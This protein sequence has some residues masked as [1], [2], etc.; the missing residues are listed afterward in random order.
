MAAIRS[1]VVEKELERSELK[2]S[3][4]EYLHKVVFMTPFTTSVTYSIGGYLR[5]RLR[6]TAQFVD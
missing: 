1:F 6:R 3:G 2:C 4:S 5:R